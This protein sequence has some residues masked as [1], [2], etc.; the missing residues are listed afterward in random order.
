M[1]P[2]IGVFGRPTMPVVSRAADDWINVSVAAKR[3]GVSL[4]TAYA[5]IHRGELHAEV[6]RTVVRP[7]G[8]RSVRL[9]RQ[10]VDDFI[11]RAKVA[12]GELRHLYS[13]AT[14]RDR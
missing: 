2:R 13:P 12:P 7:K 9:Q 6:V 1:V 5:L 4:H 14:A 11:R 3:L 8:R 10:E